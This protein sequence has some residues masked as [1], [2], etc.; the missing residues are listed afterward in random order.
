M[1]SPSTAQLSIAEYGVACGASLRM[2]SSYLP[3]SQITGFDIRPECSSICDDLDNVSV[4]ICDISSYKNDSF[5]DKY[6]LIIDDA[7]TSQ[8]ILSPHLLT[9][10]L[11]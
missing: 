6:D 11:G 8:S 1:S 2:W 3:Q 9:P 10:F 7:S 5:V 4:E